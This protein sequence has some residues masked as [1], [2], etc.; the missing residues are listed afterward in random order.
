MHS[1]STATGLEIAVVGMA[2]RLPLATDVEQF[3]AHLAQGRELIRFFTDDEL[4]VRGV[5]ET[6]LA[7]P[8]YVRALACLEAPFQFDSRFFGYTPREAEFMDP[9]LRLLHEC[10]WEALESGGCDPR[11]GEIVGLYAGSAQN[12]NWLKALS[13]HVGDN[14]T[15]L[16]DLQMLCHREFFNTRVAYRL[17]LQGP[18]LS[19]DTTCS[20]SLVAVH[21]AAQGLLSGDCDVALAGGVTVSPLIKGYVYH[22]GMIQSPDGHCRPFDAEAHGTVPGHGVGIVALKRLESAIADG[23]PIHAVLRASAVNNDG[24]DKV[25]YPAPSVTGQAKVIR[26]ALDLA[27]LGADDIDFIEC[28]GTATRIGDP[29][30]V[31]ALTQAYAARTR[32]PR[33]RIG[34]VKSNLGH[35]D[36]AAGI[37][38]LIKAVLSVRNELLPPSLHFTTPNP[39]TGLVNG[40]LEVNSELTSIARPDRPARGGVSSFGI[41]GTNAHVIVEQY[42][43]RRPSRSDPRRYRLV[44][45]AANDGPA[46]ERYARKLLEALRLRDP[47]IDAVSRTLLRRRPF[48]ARQCLVTT[49]SAELLRQLECFSADAA[50]VPARKIVF[51]F[52]GQG[53][54]YSGMGRDLYAHE[55]C[56]R[57]VVDECLGVLEP[58]LAGRLKELLLCEPSADADAVVSRTQFAQPLLFI[59]EYALARTLLCFGIQPAAMLGHSLGEFV[60]ACLAEVFSLGDALNLVCERGRLMGNAPRGAMLSVPVSAPE[61]QRYLSESVELAADNSTSMVVLAGAEGAIDE[62]TLRLRTTGIEGIRLKTRHAFHSRSMDAVIQ[63]F[64]ERLLQVQLR[65]P[66]RVYFSNRTGR[67]VSAEQAMDPRY[68]CEH[69]RH[70]VRFGDAVAALLADDPVP[71]LW[72]EVGLGSTLG[73]LVRGHQAFGMQHRC[74]QSLRHAK[75]VRPDDRLLYELLG[76]LFAAG[77]AVDWTPFEQENRGPRVALPTYAFDNTVYDQIASRGRAAAPVSDH[78]DTARAV[79]EI[80][81]PRP[82]LSTAYVEAATETELRLCELWKS[83][84]KLDSVGTDD[85]FFELGGH[86][87]LA[88]R[89][90]ADVRELFDIDM[91]LRCVFDSPT[92]RMLARNVE[93]LRTV[94]ARVPALVPAD[95]AKPIA[96]SFQQRRLWIVDRLGGG[97][98]QYNMPAPFILRGELNLPALQ[99]A[100]DT[101]VAR[102]ESL[103]TRFQDIDGEPFQIVGA[104]VPLDIPRIDLTALAEEDRVARRDLLV[105]D[106]AL[107][108]FDLSR[109]L[110]IRVTV[111]V[112]GPREHLLLINIHH[113]VSDG[114]SEVLLVKE[115]CELYAAHVSGRPP[116]LPVMN[117]QYVDYAVWQRQWMRGETL[118]AELAF[119]RNLLADSPAVH[120]LPLDRPRT[121]LP[122]HR[123]SV[124][125]REVPLALIQAVKACA[126]QHAATLFMA[127]Q[128]A[129][130]LLI[131]RWSNSEAVVMGTPIAGREQRS[132]E[133]LVGYFI[134]TLLLR[135]DLGGNPSFIELLRR[136]R[137]M[138]L[139]AF[140]HQHV[141][142][143][144][145]VENLAGDRSLGHPPL[146]QILFALQSYERTTF[147]VEGLELMRL[148]ATVSSRLDLTLITAE[149]A[150]GLITD[151]YFDTD[152]FDRDTVQR[153]AGQYEALLQALVEE[154]ERDV[155]ELP[156]ISAQERS[157][158][159]GPWQHW[160]SAGTD[161]CVAHE[162]F[163]A[164]VE[165]NPGA[166]ALSDDRERLT[167][168][169]LNQRANQL[170]A[171]LR[172]RGVTAHALVGICT[173]ATVDLIVSMLATLKCGAGYVPLDPTYPTD[174]LAYMLRDSGPAALILDNPARAPELGWHGPLLDLAAPA[175]RAEL[176]RY[177]PWDRT[178]ER[179][180][181]GECPAYV[182]YTS[183]STGQPKGV[184]IRQ[185]QLVASLVSRFALY[186]SPVQCSLLCSSV[187]FDLSV[188]VI[189][190]TL[191][192]GG[193]L[194]VCAEVE[195]KDPNAI[196]AH[197]DRL[198]VSHFI[199]L[200]SFY[201]AML[202]GIDGSRLTGRSLEVVVL[203]AEP[204][205]AE[206]RDR[207]F[208]HP[209]IRA[210][211]YNEY[212]PTECSVWS[213][214]YRC[215]RDDKDR[216]VPIG[217]SPGHARLYVLNSSGALAP[218]G[219][220]GE[221]YIG[222]DSVA[223]GYL[224][225]PALTGARFSSDP[226][227][228][229]ANARMYRSGD[230]VRW[231]R[232]GQLEFL[233]RCDQQVKLRGYRIE[234]D[235]VAAT[236]LEY[237]GITRA[238]VRVIDQRLVAYVCGRVSVDSRD[239]RA[240]VAARLPDYMVPQVVM[241]LDSLPLLPN[242]KV[243]MSRLPAP[244][245]SLPA[246]TTQQP[247]NA[248]ERE[249]AALWSDLLHVDAISVDHD[250]FAL[251]GDSILLLKLSASLSRR[252]LK[253]PLQAFY[254]RPTIQ[255]LA[256]LLE[257]IERSTEAGTPVTGEQRLHP[258]QRWFLE[259]DSTD[260]HHFNQALLLTPSP[261][262][263]FEQVR[264]AV[265]ALY[266]RHDV[267]RLQFVEDPAGTWRAAYRDLDESLLDASCESVTLQPGLD[268][269][270]AAAIT[271]QAARVQASLSLAGPLIRFIHLRL[272][273]RTA[274]CL[275]VAH[276]LI[277]DGVSW[278]VLL[279]DLHEACRQGL[280]GGGIRLAPKTTSY[281][282]FVD[283]LHELATTE[284]IRRERGYWQ[285]V[286]QT[287]FDAIDATADGS[288]T[289]A[290]EE[291]AEIIFEPG[292]TQALLRGSHLAYGM[293]VDEVLLAALSL[294]MLRWRNCRRLALIIEGHG[295]SLLESELSVAETVGWFTAY[296][297]LV[298]TGIT[299]DPAALLRHT[300]DQLRQVP[301]RGAHYGLARYFSEGA[302]LDDSAF[303]LQGVTFNY[304]GQFD[305]SKRP[306]AL[307]APAE[308]SAGP[309][310]SGSRRRSG[311]LV[312]DGMVTNG[313][314]RF[315]VGY[316]RRQLDA[317]SI[318]ALGNEFR[319][320]LA[321]LSAHWQ[322]Q[323][324]SAWTAG[325]FPLLN[326]QE[327]E[328][329]EWSARWP[330]VQDAYPATSVQQGMIFHTL[331][332]RSLGRSTYLT[333]LFM[334]IAGAVDVSRLREAWRRVIERH[335]VFRTAFVPLSG[336]GVAQVVLP[337]EQASLSFTSR[338]LA[339][340][341]PDE[342]EQAIAQESAV[343]RATHFRLDA[344]PLT[345]VLLWK[346]GDQHYRLLWT[347][348]HAILD[349]WSIPLVLQSLAR[350]YA[351]IPDPDANAAPGFKSYVSWLQAQDKPA[352]ERFWRDQLARLER[353]CLLGSTSAR[354]TEKGAGQVIRRLG[355]EQFSAL[356]QAARAAGVTPYSLIQA[357]WAYLLH[358]YT[359]LRTVVFGS[360]I[361]GRPATLPG[362][363]RMAGLFI[364][365]MPIQV[366]LDFTRR[367]DH[368][369]RDIHEHHLVCQAHGYIGLAEILKLMPAGPAEIFNSVL[370][371]QN[372]PLDTAADAASWDGLHVS[373][374]YSEESTEAPVTLVAMPATGL[375]L[376]LMYSRA[377]L[378][379]TYA[380]DLLE[381]LTQILTAIPACRE[382]ELTVLDEAVA[383]KHESD[384]A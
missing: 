61:A 279:D 140:E 136:T 72:V 64:Y 108:P 21:I 10:C 304:L 28:H 306:D 188:P 100:F 154:P 177:P 73:G 202:E 352:A 130:A 249:L 375:A 138:T 141:P 186:E 373:D 57:A 311:G 44:P 146:F 179:N 207:H 240:F 380:V 216:S 170:A 271:L 295:R 178:E 368:W 301:A 198:G 117:V 291:H 52:P 41:G 331:K 334:S 332:D 333:Q 115:F 293:T 56:Y 95:R 317:K 299:E 247:M 245:V 139:S 45:L 58:G 252:N 121:R 18:V 369:V 303:H 80:H 101:M 148:E 189:F 39:L 194:H 9:Q 257:P 215:L 20:T 135:T 353:P 294:G 212:G 114:W 244:V 82:K 31:E 272:P 330:V 324:L 211:L 374:V 208:A 298:L 282:T 370:V 4:R 302:P 157:L 267:L 92:P 133:S 158:V 183:G 84:F 219:V 265:G 102:H 132:L 104:P 123:G 351:R 308:E 256:T 68:W 184:L 42:I 377:E 36:A 8:A 285:S 296:Y 288:G 238:V 70:T 318:E 96:A 326:L 307:F 35:L 14:V 356:E 329:L 229:Q 113:I 173:Q 85:N 359:G 347:C 378:S 155:F 119:W 232:D 131:A 67:A 91:P 281:Q 94:T 63:P 236:L 338:D 286:L 55:P 187:S 218:P 149:G 365:T 13:Q 364:N 300:K 209:S 214:F 30:E 156:L 74:L 251:G 270:R 222:G 243:D 69:L 226:F 358:L 381:H 180:E 16:Y 105:R 314:L 341:S 110:P 128:A 192:T 254:P 201:G 284:P 24:H 118:E 228:P 90:L 336:G 27:Q 234:P 225:Q 127:L 340:L 384:I 7:S 124:M 38:G 221:L 239:I 181:R 269:T 163:A 312:F 289:V 168:G 191:S 137:A 109:D 152:L 60:A 3:W 144:M 217:R 89:V 25:G 372:Y 290:D 143:E 78:P 376:K 165:R 354:R 346:L 190:W 75:D 142:F 292:P 86:S 169:E 366:S 253:F 363:E 2:V 159:L 6:E 126:Q 129:F 171:G 278:P 206:V 125:R 162:W 322:R 305:G 275:I 12:L 382:L 99:S 203:V 26:A 111:A 213:T 88:T 59:V 357:A 320:A 350:G 246:T 210:A 53:T 81:H 193:R 77:I 23:N 342:Q 195:R 50:A 37:A 337:A 235:E 1:E 161:T 122:R 316:D 174:R 164:C 266:A 145:L 32:T 255:H 258:I 297:P 11:L 66:K 205:I 120:G 147:D 313:V 262:V 97:S 309:P 5:P 40:P 276:H 237:P 260:R 274:R 379:D 62:L 287:P 325:D 116:Q 150:D 367:L 199:C 54:Q 224:Q 383:E 167:Y 160:A 103:R 323:S 22:E 263:T 264:K 98:A 204:L 33:C 360:V 349:G 355:R 112:L 182:I 315:K 261:D 151:W 280:A 223:E 175:V 51:L 172:A 242:G 87:L 328:L 47:G 34:S 17:N 166:L 319:R 49:D 176:S 273:D 362:A 65:P 335:E 277:V 106:D 153:M 71:T 345:R 19:I 43:E 227:S 233:G 83:V 196:A 268:Q 134:N 107:K 197:I 348:H 230:R 344:P 259:G 361:S 48:E 343:D 29:I 283:R 321:E 339:P 46:L 371:Y 250:F 76:Q 200:P 15:E 241:V 185:K 310:V 248:R 220:S 93:E 231:R 327:T 79:R